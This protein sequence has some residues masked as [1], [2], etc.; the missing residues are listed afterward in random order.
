MVLNTV[1]ISYHVTHRRIGSSLSERPEVLGQ[2]FL[3][4]PDLRLGYIEIP[5]SELGVYPV[6][7][8][9]IQVALVKRMAGFQLVEGHHAGMCI[10]QVR[11]AQPETRR[12][13]VPIAE[14]PPESASVGRSP[15]LH[16]R[17]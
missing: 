12:P 15:H 10:H 1:P 6:R 17:F 11:R 8:R 16:A 7:Q 4:K 9:E 5:Q 2:V 13:E 14:Q 3:Q